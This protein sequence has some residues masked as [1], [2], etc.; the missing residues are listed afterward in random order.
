M[1]SVLGDHDG[2]LA[3]VDLLPRAHAPVFGVRV[4][5]LCDV[6]VVRPVDGDGRGADGGDR[7]LVERHDLEPVGGLDL[8]LAV[9]GPATE[10]PERAS[11]VTAECP[12]TR[13]AP[14]LVLGVLRG[15]G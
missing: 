10:S 15:G 11:T 13:V 14:L 2:G 3:G 5:L 9:D 1:A 4:D 8:E 12:M 6:L 7:A